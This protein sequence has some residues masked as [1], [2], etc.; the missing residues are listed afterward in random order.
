MNAVLLLA[1]A[2]STDPTWTGLAWRAL[3]AITLLVLN[4][5]FVAAEF[6]A[7]GAR[8][9]RLEEQAEYSLAARWGLGIKYKLDLYLSTCQ[10]GITISSLG[11]GY[12]VEP[13]VAPLFEPILGWM[14]IADAFGPHVL[15]GG[16]ALLLMTALHVVVGE[17][18]PKNLAIFYPD[19]LIVLLAI[20]LVIFTGAFYPFIWVLNAASNQLLKLC[21]VPVE[22]ASHGA[23]PHTANELRNLLRQA[24]DAGTIE[25]GDAQLLHGAFDFGGLKVRQI[26]IPRVDVD[27]ILSDAP[28]GDILK[29]VQTS[30]YTRLP[31]CDK[32]LDHVVGLVHMKD[33]FA[34]L[35]LVTGRL[36]FA[37]EMTPEGEAIAIAG[38]PN[39]PGAETHVIGSGSVDLHKVKR[40]ILF[41]PE[42][43]PVVKA[44]RQMQ[45][46]RT[47]MGVVVDEYGGTVGV[48][49]LED[50]VEQIV[51]DIEDEFDLEEV[52]GDRRFEKDGEIFRTTGHFPLHELRDHL[53]LAGW[54]PPEEVDTVGGYI[55]ARLGRWPHV[56]DVAPLGDKAQYQV[57]VTAIT[58][59][60]QMTLLIAPA[61][62]Q[63][64]RD[65]GPG[66]T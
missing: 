6:A 12:V 60:R 7:V 63:Q 47:H 32:D 57:R 43:L 5:F 8:T 62:Q 56:G 34:Q 3:V 4:G 24:T 61:T 40:E 20:P 9:S 17:V 28:I 46:F 1:A 50:V 19:R 51:G 25:P 23:L 2:T 54:Q 66:E 39:L 29:K 33:L 15:A 18:A 48:V 31:L 59:E 44:M 27:Y 65:D 35:K 16:V 21:G 11:L 58:A 45:Q 41:I 36:K 42:L 30:E 13:A 49:T 53:P 26:M 37:D 38:G 22:E 55:T 64:A 14:G 10:V 52:E